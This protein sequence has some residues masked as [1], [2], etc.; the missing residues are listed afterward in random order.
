MADPSK[1]SSV[2]P[3]TD[4]PAVRFVRASTAKNLSPRSALLSPQRSPLVSP[5]SPR[6]SPRG[7]A[8]HCP[9]DLFFSLH[10]SGQREPDAKQLTPPPQKAAAMAVVAMRRVGSEGA[11]E[12]QEAARA[13]VPVVKLA[14]DVTLNSST[15]KLLWKTAWRRSVI[16][17]PK[18]ASEETTSEEA[19]E[20][21]QLYL[22]SRN[23]ICPVPLSMLKQAESVVSVCCGSSHTAILTDL[24][25]VFTWG[26]GLLG[27]LGHGTTTSVVEPRLLQ[28]LDGSRV[29]RVAAGGTQTVVVTTDDFLWFGAFRAN[30]K[31]RLIPT[32]VES[33]SAL[34]V[35]ARKFGFFCII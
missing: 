15:D 11:Q 21:K 1:E 28:A 31:P 2:K 17:T 34:V 5:R 9:S 32:V 8:V 24:H 16:N 13:N 7:I 3:S 30:D 12:T 20:N 14:G 33:L 26:S 4:L 6:G 18:P 10:L 22:W 27:Q 19:G 35:R 29:N 25:R 23:L